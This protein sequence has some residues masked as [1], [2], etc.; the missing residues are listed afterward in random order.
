MDGHFG[1]VHHLREE[2]GGGVTTKW[3]GCTVWCV[4]YG[5][6]FLI[7]KVKI[8]III[9]FTTLCYYLHHQIHGLVHDQPLF[10]MLHKVKNCKDINHTS[11]VTTFS[12]YG[13]QVAA[14]NG[15][16]RIPARK[17]KKHF[18]FDDDDTASYLTKL[19]E[20][21]IVICIHCS[22]RI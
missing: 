11:H 19:V 21:W 8:T 3:C 9:S 4:F 7:E 14:I 17:T 5:Y 18:Q 1:D 6:S 16:R 12:T 2:G 22:W 20:R 13:G 10:Q 15:G